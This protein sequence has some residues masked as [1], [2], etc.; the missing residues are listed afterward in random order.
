MNLLHEMGLSR[1]GNPQKERGTK[2][3]TFAKKTHPFVNDVNTRGSVTQN[4]EE[5]YETTG[6]D[7][8]QNRSMV[9]ENANHIYNSL[10]KH[11]KRILERRSKSLARRGGGT[12]SR[13]GGRCPL[14][15]DPKKGDLAQCDKSTKKY[16]GAT[17]S[18]TQRADSNRSLQTVAV[19]R[20]ESWLGKVRMTMVQGS[21]VGGG[22]RGI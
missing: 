22:K 5:T 20:D 14:R 1:G 2:S 16:G 13:Q 9:E 10:R 6:T 7:R 21:T 4:V 17:T 12:R 18:K 11:T 15:T 3:T 19:T 8:L